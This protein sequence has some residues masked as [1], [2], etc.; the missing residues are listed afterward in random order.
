MQAMMYF[1][2]LSEKNIFDTFNFE[3]NIIFV[4]QLDLRCFYSTT[5]C[6]MHIMLNYDKYYENRR[7]LSVVLSVLET[8]VHNDNLSIVISNKK[9]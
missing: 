7:R 8:T 2:D 5:L 6:C 9:N 1:N 3:L 4:V